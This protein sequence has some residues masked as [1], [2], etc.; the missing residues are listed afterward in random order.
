[1]ACVVAGSRG[2]CR[3]EREVQRWDEVSFLTLE[4]CRDP[5]SLTEWL[6]VGG[7]RGRGKSIP[8]RESWAA[9]CGHAQS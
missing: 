5:R 6:C 7:E 1:M 4:L 8:N 9:D 2:R 3:G